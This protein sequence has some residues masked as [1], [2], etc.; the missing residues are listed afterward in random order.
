M[1]SGVHMKHVALAMASA[2]QLVA[3][4]TLMAPVTSFPSA[5]TACATQR[6]VSSADA[7]GANDVALVRPYSTNTERLELVVL[8]PVGASPSVHSPALPSAADTLKSNALADATA[9]VSVT[10]PSAASVVLTAA[11]EA[12]G[13]A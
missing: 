4:V 8:A 10:G 9:S 5:S 7:H 3:S 11:A 1:A 12:H 6:D 2:L 13:T